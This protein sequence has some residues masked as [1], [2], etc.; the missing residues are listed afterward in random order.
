[1]A[2]VPQYKVFNNLKAYIASCK[3]IQD[4]AYLAQSYGEGASVRRG[5]SQKDIVLLIDSDHDSKSIDELTEDAIAGEERL[6]E[7]WRMRM[8]G[9]A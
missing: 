6:E 3:E 1:M 4:A 7:K 5:H 8:R 9:G 2:A